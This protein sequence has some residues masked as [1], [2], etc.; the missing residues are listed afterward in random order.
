MQRLR[1]VG[2]QTDQSACNGI[3]N[4]HIKLVHRSRRRT[5][6]G[7]MPALPGGMQRLR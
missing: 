4:L 5:T 7:K 3:S 6:K 1:G 2:K